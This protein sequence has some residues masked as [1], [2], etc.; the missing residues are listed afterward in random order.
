MN[1]TFQNSA[2]VLSIGVFFTPDDRRAVAATCRRC[3]SR[4]SRR[5]ACPPRTPRAVAG[6]PPVGVLFAAFLGYNPIQ[7]LLG[8]IAVRRCPPTRPTYLTGRSF[9][10]QLISGP[11]ADG[12]T[13][14]FWFAIV[15]CLVAA[16]ASWFA[17][18]RSRGPRHESVGDELAASSGELVIDEAPR[19]PV[20]G[21]LMGAVRTVSGSTVLDSV[22][23]VTDAQG[24]QRGRSVAAPNGHYAVGGLDSGE[25]T[26]VASSP[27]FRPTVAT[28]TLNGRG[29]T[30]DFAL[31]G[32]GGVRGVVDDGA[33]PIPDAV[34]IVTDAQGRVV[35]RTRSATDGTFALNGLP[36][37]PATVTA[38]M[39]QHQPAATAVSI[40]PAD[41]APVELRLLPSIGGLVGTVLAPDG[42]VVPEATVTASDARGDIVGS[43]RSDVDGR[44][45]LAD[46]PP[47]PL[48]GGRDHLR[49]RR[50]A[51]R[52]CPRARPRRSTCG[53]ARSP[54]RS[55]DQPRWPPRSSSPD[56]CASRRAGSPATGWARSGSTA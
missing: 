31:D 30:H 48:H 54:G 33:A 45:R 23:T 42:S 47:G 26:V 39:P 14:A 35:G 21:Q 32:H 34:V 15:A 12:L 38:S 43:T 37:G 9:F 4:A 13:A 18:G 20:A 29:A 53:W 25:Y 5:T 44:Y 10:P 28:V 19:E 49:A 1:A 8:P 7:Q 46:L 6:L 56:G 24:T 40:G 27:G 51:G 17:S 55:H 3:W 50:R 41:P 2:M 36:L 11:F 52:R 22:V 16:V